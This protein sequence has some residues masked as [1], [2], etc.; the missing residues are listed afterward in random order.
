M[1]DDP[2]QGCVCSSG[3]W[4]GRWIMVGRCVW[5]SVGLCVGDEVDGVLGKVV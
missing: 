3:V 4:V 5:D 2:S 1:C